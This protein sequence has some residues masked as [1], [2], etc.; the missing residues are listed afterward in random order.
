MIDLRKDLFSNLDKQDCS[1]DS[2]HSLGEL[3]THLAGNAQ[4]PKF[5]GSAGRLDEA[6]AA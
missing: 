6:L 3:T 5:T 2:Q 4:C 1:K